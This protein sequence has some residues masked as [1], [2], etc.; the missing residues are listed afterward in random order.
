[1]LG[2]D[3]ERDIRLLDA[4]RD[5]ILLL[6]GGGG[7]YQ[8][9]AFVMPDQDCLNAVLQDGKTDFAT[10]GPPD[11]WYAASPINPFL[12]VGVGPDPL[13][14]HCTGKAK[15]WILTD[16]P[17]RSPNIYES[18]WY[19]YAYLETPWVRVD[20]CLPRGVKEWLAATRLGRIAGTISR[21][22]R[23]IRSQG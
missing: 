20:N 2:L 3:V 23:R 4:W 13:L 18:T 9:P 6:R 16:V 8:D 19:R 22:Q 21:I 14:L 7:M 5:A 11:V 10:I 12:H 1:M 15:P 17:P